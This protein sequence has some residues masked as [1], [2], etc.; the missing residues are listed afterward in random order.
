MIDDQALQRQ[1]S[2]PAGHIVVAHVDQATR[3]HTTIQSGHEF[4]ASGRRDPCP[5]AVSDRVVELPEGRTTRCCQVG[6]GGLHHP[7]VGQPC[8]IDQSGSDGDMRRIEVDT[9]EFRVRVGRRHEAHAHAGAASEFKVPKRSGG[10]WPAKPR[11][12][13]AGRQVRGRRLEID[14]ARVR[15][16]GNVACAPR[17]THCS[18]CF[19][20]SAQPPRWRISFNR[21][22][23][24]FGD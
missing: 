22:A 10:V 15:H 12:E 2:R 21:A 3:R 11:E 8:F 17:H 7:R 13:R 6:E 5:D 1:R 24:L 23:D 9:D 20:L 16:I 19:C 14:A 18:G 4:A